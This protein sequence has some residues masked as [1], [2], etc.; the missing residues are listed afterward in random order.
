M[1][2][3]KEAFFSAIQLWSDIFHQLNFSFYEQQKN[4][5]LVSN[6]RN[7]NNKNFFDRAISS[8]PHTFLARSF[9]AHLIILST[10][11]NYKCKIDLKVSISPTI[12]Q[13]A[14]YLLQKLHKQILCTYILCYYFF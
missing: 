2:F 9:F 6:V 5:K 1:F 4:E 10:N 11:F 8:P 12:S 7:V 14:I 13:A 3:K